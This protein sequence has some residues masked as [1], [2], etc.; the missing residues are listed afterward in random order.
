MVAFTDALSLIQQSGFYEIVIPFILVYAVVYGVLLR[1]GVIQGKELQAIVALAIAVGVVISPTARTFIATLVPYFTGFGIVLFMFAF[2]LLMGGMKYE[3]I[4]KIVGNFEEGRYTLILAIAILLLFVVMASAFP[5]VSSA[6]IE[7]LAE[8][9]NKTLSEKV[10]ELSASER[11]VFFLSLP[12]VL[13]L[14][15]LFFIFAIAAFV[16]ANST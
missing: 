14:V 7:K 2:V 11:A 4:L 3:E 5:N 6:N 9:E 1:S 12:Q 13:G 8:E 16:I 10:E 15:V